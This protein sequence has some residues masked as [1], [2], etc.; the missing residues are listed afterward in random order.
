MSS[1]LDSMKAE[2][3][4]GTSAVQSD[5]SDST[6][7]SFTPIGVTQDSN[8]LLNNLGYKSSLSKTNPEYREESMAEIIGFASRMGFQ[9]TWR[10]VKQLLGSDEEEMKR[11]QERLNRYLK[12]EEYGGSVMAA[13]T[14][15][16][17]GDP[18]GW[19]LPGM[20]ARN[21]YKAA[22]AGLV[23]GGI[24]GATGYVDE[25]NGMTRLNQ[26][27]IGIAG[28]GI[29]SPAM[30]KFQ[31]TIMP[32]M[33]NGY[34]NLG[35]AID[36]NKI[37][38]ELNLLQKGITGVAG[39]AYSGV[40]KVGSKISETKAYNKFGNYFID[41]FGLPDAVKVAKKN[42]RLSENKWAGDFNEVLERFAK[43]T[44]LQDRALYRL[45]TGDKLSAKENSLLTAD[46]RALGVEGR[47]VVNAL[48][49]ELVD[50]GLLDPKTF[51]A[52]KNSYLHRSYEKYAD[53]LKRK[54]IVT[55]EENLGVIA[56][57][58]MRRGK[59]ETF[60]LGKGQTKASLIAQKRLEGWKV[61]DSKG[62]NIRMNRDWTAKE[63]T[64]MGEM[65]SATFA[66]AKT[67]K[68]MSNDVAAFKFY[69][70]IAKM[71]DDVAIKGTGTQYTKPLGV[72]EDWKRV[73]LD[74]V[75]VGGNDTKVRKY[76]NLA[77]HWVSPE[78]H[79][80]LKWASIAKKYSQ[81]EYGGAAKL[82][83][84]MLQY[85]KRTKTSLNP[86]V[87][88]NNVMSNF[89]LFDLVNAQYKHLAGAGKDFYKAFNP[90]KANRVESEDFKLAKK[91][92]VF[93]AD[94]MKRELT[95]FEIDTWKKYMKIGE[96]NDSKLL[97]KIWEG[98][99]KYAGKTHMDRLYSAEDSV[100][101]LGLFKDRLSK[102]LANNMGKDEASKDAAMFARKYML[103]YE[104]DAPGVQLMR[105]TMMPFISYTYR[106][107]PI[108][109]ETL[110][111]RP[112][113]IA[114]WGLI[115][116]GANQ[117]ATDD[118]EAR[119]ERKRLNELNMGFNV[120][121]IPGA[122]TMIK[123]PTDRLDDK[124]RY[125][126]V[127]RWIPAGDVL[128]TKEQGLNIPFLPAPLQPSGGALGGIGKA[129]TGFDTFT[130]Q[131][132]AGVGSGSMKDELSARIP[133]LGGGRD[134]ILG[135]EFI[136]MWNQGWNIFE[137]YASGGKRHPT[138][139]DK[140]MSEAMM[141][142]IGIK[143]K[144]YDDKKMKTRIH[145]K[146]Q[147][148]IESLTSKIKKLVRDK[149]GG[150]AGGDSYA[151]EIERLKSELKKIQIEARQAL[152]KAK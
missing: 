75:K 25:D 97:E 123:L 109:A 18:V 151:S 2:Y 55:D 61:I 71:G 70:D 127:S 29:L 28:G 130:A 44:P 81:D 41:N 7:P 139:D 106:A 56:T 138:K 95:N 8:S 77:G 65:V 5:I 126:D 122:N 152:K 20:K 10:G 144:S 137:A 145:Y 11:D 53:P 101:R 59:T 57:E 104:I 49:K 113:K 26:T 42:R 105:E 125:L 98:S 35:T 112:W 31:K 103:D 15:G 46:I 85:W 149:K 6:K 147:N 24:I 135:K 140:T 39:P 9:D 76:G 129:I 60:K 90:I 91:L 40:K 43:L 128:T 148:K 110:L 141:Q 32:N 78:V 134:S 114:K 115:L 16:L 47:T 131:R 118:S 88:M 30:Y 48:G 143:V 17:F 150:R 116:N 86:V 94:I 111:K 68:L 51:L 23:S 117:L 92:G 89:V 107:A 27:M 36:E 45:M 58:F 83:H 33:K 133:L 4:I 73:S 69:D 21:A 120:L 102:N 108:I 19:F 96:Q 72:P 54:K 62:N 52:N 119:T 84:K 12:N 100:F 13:Y 34:R 1:L 80:D 146:Y 14:A 99:K 132:Q 63:R 50:L 142:T 64:D 124:S 74:F 37:T 87:H 22:K 93:D 82:H 38:S 136:P 67:G 66:L 121:S 3:N 79:R